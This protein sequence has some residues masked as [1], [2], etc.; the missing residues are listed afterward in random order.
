METL[1]QMILPS[2]VLP[3]L[4]SA[5]VWRLDKRKPI[6]LWALPL[7]WLASFVWLIGWPSIIP[8]EANQWLYPLALCSVLIS[9]YIKFSNNLVT[10]LQTLLLV[11]GLIGI[12]WPVLQYQFSWML[13][14]ELL[15]VMI[16]G[17]LLF[18]FSAKPHA[19]T[20]ALTMFVS[21]GGMGLVVALGGSLLIGQLAGALASILISFAVVELMTKL[22]KPAANLSSFV[23]VIQLYL[24]I[25]VIARIFAE[26]PLGPSALLL[27]APLVG[28]ISSKRYAFVI[29]VVSVIAALSWLLLAA[30]S[31]SY[32]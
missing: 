20:P 11:L 8:A 12:I 1:I 16:I 3:I 17:C 9:L 32:Y 19:K 21:S 24:G 23:P 5:I 10:V 30:D 29:S 2:T 18:Y 27:I 15:V 25:L 22:Q 6:A 4:L 28:L 14:L 31:S 13:V 26:I 7:I